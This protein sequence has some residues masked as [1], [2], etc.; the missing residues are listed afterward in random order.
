MN[1]VITSTGHMSHADNVVV[2]ANGG[3]EVSLCCFGVFVCLLGFSGCR[4]Y[5]EHM[6]TTALFNQVITDDIDRRRPRC[7]IMEVHQ[8]HIPI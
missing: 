4:T 8:Q 5:D 1:I 3:L 2:G 6:M 7:C